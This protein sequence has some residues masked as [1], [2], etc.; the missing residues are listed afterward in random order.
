MPPITALLHTR[1]DALRIGRAL[2]TLLP[3]AEI[4]IVDHASNDAT[5][6]IA[7]AYGARIMAAD[8]RSSDERSSS[9]FLNQALNHAHHNWILCLRPSESLT[10]A[11]QATLFEWSLLPESRLNGVCAFSLNVRQRLLREPADSA[12]V[13]RGQTEI[14]E[15]K[16]DWLAGVTLETRLIP[17]SWNS[18]Q[19]FLPTYEA[20]AMALDGELLQFDFP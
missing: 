15:N 9:L 4:L 2:E 1:N 12:K 3:C 20:S 16:E 13:N 19:H 14:A 11:L 5:V 10:E 18:W 8:S 7:R 6:R 17:R